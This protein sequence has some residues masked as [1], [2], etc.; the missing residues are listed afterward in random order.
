[1]AA[2][3]IFMP[4]ASQ[5]RLRRTRDGCSMQEA[6][7][8]LLTENLV[9]ATRGVV[10]DPAATANERRLAAIVESILSDLPNCP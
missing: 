3:E 6:K 2:T 10:A 9:G 1:M 8:R 5:V 7:K 4:S